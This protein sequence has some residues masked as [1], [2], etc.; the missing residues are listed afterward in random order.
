MTK[1]PRISGRECV[2]ALQRAGFEIKRQ[3]GSH[4]VLRRVEPFAMAV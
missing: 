4:V 2:I 3:T 1:L